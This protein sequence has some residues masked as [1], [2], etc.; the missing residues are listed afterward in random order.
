MRADLHTHST[1]S[2]GTSTPDALVREAAARDISLLALTDHDTMAGCPAAVA[3]G[4]RFGV[5][6][7]PGVELTASLDGVS[8]HLLAWFPTA[9]P[10]R[11]LQ[12]LE[13]LGDV[14]RERGQQIVE[15]LRGLGCSIAFDDVRATAAGAPITRPVIARTLV[16][17]GD[18]ASV[19]DAFDRYLAEG[20][21]AYMPSGAFNCLGAI[22][23][24]HSAGGVTCLA[25]PAEIRLDRVGIERLVARLVDGGLDAIEVN[26]PDT[27]PGTIEWLDG[28]ARLHDLAASCGSD[29]HG[30][31]GEERGRRLGDTDGIGYGAAD[32]FGRLRRLVGDYAAPAAGVGQ[33]LA[34]PSR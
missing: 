13:R 30:A 21:P 28:V 15:R 26:R 5:C 17:A 18:A 2:D 22:Q 25:H 6:V 9:A 11:L 34:L 24:V 33:V 31:A 1:A 29:Y 12:R 27:A 23:L 3:A 14:R 19:Q 20:R 4:R 7:V 32:L 16:A 10:F 8:V